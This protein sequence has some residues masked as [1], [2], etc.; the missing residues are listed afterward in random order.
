MIGW[1]L[2]GGAAVLVFGCASRLLWV[3]AEIAS[4]FDE[5]M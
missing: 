4:M 2:F 1:I 5:D 3:A